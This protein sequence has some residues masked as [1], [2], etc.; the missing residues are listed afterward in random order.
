MT[1]FTRLHI[2]LWENGMIE[3]FHSTLIMF[4]R[5]VVFERQKG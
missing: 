5:K 2:D 4:L 3:R 1:K